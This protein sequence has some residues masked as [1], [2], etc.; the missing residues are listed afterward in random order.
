MLTDSMEEVSENNLEIGTIYY[1]EHRIEPTTR[2][3]DEGKFIGHKMYVSK[4]MP[5]FDI[6]KAGTDKNPQEGW[7]HPGVYRFFKRPQ[8]VV[9]KRQAI[10]ALTNKKEKGQPIGEDIQKEISSYLGGKKKGGKK[11]RSR[12]AKKSR[13][14]EQKGKGIGKKRRWSLKYKRS[15]NCKRPKGFSQKQYCKR[16][17]LKKTRRNKKN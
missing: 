9:L 11:R 6:R 15:I 3:R 13:K 8:D 7:R 14:A 4:K 16:I 17:N 5:Y 1:I 12:K 2:P 10:T